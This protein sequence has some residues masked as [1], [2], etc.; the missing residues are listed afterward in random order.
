MA[1]CGAS[2]I[3]SELENILLNSPS[4]S[5]NSNNSE[6]MESNS[7]LGFIRFSTETVHNE[8][9]DRLRYYRTQANEGN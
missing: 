1:G 6:M 2:S 3:S 5:K 7:D 4:V 8:L 9:P